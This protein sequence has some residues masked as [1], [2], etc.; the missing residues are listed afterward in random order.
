MT[1]DEKPKKWFRRGEPLSRHALQSLLAII[2][3]GLTLLFIHW[4]HGITEQIILVVSLGS[5]AF[6]VFAMPH[7]RTAS[8]RNLVGGQ[9]ACFVIGKLFAYGNTAYWAQLLGLN[10]ELHAA[11][12]TA[13][14]VGACDDRRRR[15]R[16]CRGDCN[17]RRVA[18]LAVGRRSH[19]SCRRGGSLGLSSPAAQQA[20]GFVLGDRSQTAEN[21]E[22]TVTP[23]LNPEP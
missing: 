20:Q 10:P 3:V 8:P 11:L 12:V 17:G 6:V 22:S 5:S 13:A 19:G 16:A 7:Q 18:S 21:H 23:F 1:G 2:F 4:L 9:L 15:T 14:T